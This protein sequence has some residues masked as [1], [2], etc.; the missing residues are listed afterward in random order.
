MFFLTK[1]VLKYNKLSPNLHGHLCAWHDRNKHARFKEELLPRGHF[2][3][4]VITIGGGVQL[5]LPSDDLLDLPVV[6]TL[7]TNGRYLICHELAESASAFLLEITGHF[8]A[9]PTLMALFP[10]CVPVRG[11]QRINLAE[12]ELPRSQD[13]KEAT[14][15]TMGVGGRSQGYHYNYLKL[16]DLIGDKAR[17]SKTEMQ[18][19]KNW[20]DNIQSFFSSFTE[21]YLDL[22][23]TRWA[24]DDLYQHA[25][26]QYG[27]KLLKYIRPA[28]E[29]IIDADGNKQ[30]VPIFPE[31]FTTESFEIIK[32]NK[33]VWSAQYANNPAAGG[34]LLEQRW[35]KLY[36]WNG[37]NRILYNKTIYNVE[38]MDRVILIDPAMEGKA[39]FVVTGMA[40]DGMIFILEALKDSW[41]PPDLVDL[42]FQQTDRWQ[43]R[44]VAIE[45]V[46]FSGLF[47]H[48]L[49][50][51][52]KLRGKH[53][54]VEPIST[55]GKAKE[56]RVLG[57]S[58]YF[59]AGQIAFH[60]SQ[61]DLLEEFDT[62]GATDN[63]HMLDALAQGPQVWRKGV[64]KKW[65]EDKEK[66]YDSVLKDRHPI[67]GY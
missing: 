17:D 11:K 32:K 58:N 42:I 64:A 25:A 37:H 29:V 54:R 45:K 56:A 9:N 41:R 15:D 46:L 7:G 40:S 22:V 49:K 44:I 55:G 53:F 14:Y 38:E 30:L 4:T 62:F 8:L 35:K 20:F 23:G 3:S 6:H 28:E 57:L 34:T 19:A 5:G 60:P 26:D 36:T 39:G 21:D 48:W 27:V 47:E 59:A 43:A 50:D 66:A 31:Q 16:D 18:R 33:V 61:V 12:L 65:L 1:G 52:M 13:W 10:E 2:K 24:F 51:A 63:Y 67:G